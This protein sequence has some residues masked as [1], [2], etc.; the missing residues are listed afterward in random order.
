MALDLTFSST[1]FLASFV[2]KLVA[3][4]TP[5]VEKLSPIAP[6]NFESPQH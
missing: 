4:K 6:T 5:P 2:N 3:I 1:Y